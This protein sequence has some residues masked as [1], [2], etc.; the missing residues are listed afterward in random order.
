MYIQIEEII[1]N[2]LIIGFFI[3]TCSSLYAN[4]T[5][6]VRESFA[7]NS[8]KVSSKLIKFSKFELK[9]KGYDISLDLDKADYSLVL[10]GQF[11]DRVNECRTYPIAVR[12]TLYGVDG[13]PISS[14]STFSCG[15]I[16]IKPIQRKILMKRQIKNLPL[17]KDI[18]KK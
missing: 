12:S 1:L 7:N 16:P 15:I 10:E 9:K 8:E 5:V 2:K 18:C 11:E 6:N 14:E 13:K 4:C 17:A 3:L